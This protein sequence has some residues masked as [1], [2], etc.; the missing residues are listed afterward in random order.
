MTRNALNE[1]EGQSSA[2][3]HILQ[4]IRSS[5]AHMDRIAASNKGSKAL[6]KIK[7]KMTEMAALAETYVAEG[8]RSKSAHVDDSS[9]SE[10]GEL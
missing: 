9:D 8:K 2:E 6:R 4:G 10:D 7:R 5:S 1:N 3:A